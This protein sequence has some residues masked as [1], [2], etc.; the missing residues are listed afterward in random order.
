MKPDTVKTIKSFL[1]ALG[2]LFYLLPLLLIAIP[3]TIISESNQPYDFNLGAGRYLGWLPIIAGCI[4]HFWCSFSFVFS[5]QG[6]PITSMPPKKLVIKGL[7]RFVRNP[8]YIASLL[9][10]AGEVILFQSTG[11]FIYLL[12][13]FGVMHVL[14]VGWEEKRLEK[15]FG[16]SYRRYRQAV[17]RWIPRLTPY[18]EDDLESH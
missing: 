17:P 14:L 11:V 5:G 18:R 1:G 7:H 2:F 13:L 3:Y 12:G 6:T 4:I 16:E 8:I 10:L 15:R 9:I